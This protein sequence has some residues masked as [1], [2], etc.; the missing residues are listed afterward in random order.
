M[1]NRKFKYL[2][3]CVFALV[4]GVTGTSCIPPSSPLSRRELR[5]APPTTRSAYDEYFA[6]VLGESD[7]AHLKEYAGEFGVDYRLVLAII[8][9]ESSF[10][11]DAVS[12]RGAV[13]LM[14]LMPVTNAEIFDALDMD[15]SELP[16]QN[17]RAGIYYVAKLMNLFADCP[18]R[19]RMALALAAYNAGPS[20]IY[21]AQE[22]SAYMGENPHTWSSVGNMLPLLSKRYY[23]L[24]QAVWEGGKPHSGYYGSWRQTVAYVSSTL[25]TYDEYAAVPE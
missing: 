12:D 6:D 11:G 23:S 16:R 20:R 22:L 18:A 17:L 15:G 25:R 9:H 14:Q 10:N 3:I 1:S 13:G 19:D 5:T 24:H 2:E 4:L 7:F 8:K 21:D